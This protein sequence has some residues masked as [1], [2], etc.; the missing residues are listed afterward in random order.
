M[1]EQELKDR[2]QEL[3]AQVEALVLTGA[4]V[5]ET[6][7]RAADIHT[8]SWAAATLRAIAHAFGETNNKL[9]AAFGEDVDRLERLRRMEEP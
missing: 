5:Y 3:E 9:R 7:L 4:W 6:A 1:T 2:I 8:D